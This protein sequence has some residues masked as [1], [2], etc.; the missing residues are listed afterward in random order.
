MMHHIERDPPVNV[1]QVASF[2]IGAGLT[3]LGALALLYLIGVVLEIVIAPGDSDLVTWVVENTGGEDL[4]VSGKVNE[5]TFEFRSSAALQYM[6][7]GM[8]ALFL[9]SLVMRIVQGI[10][11]TGMK[12]IE[13]SKKLEPREPAAPDSAVSRPGSET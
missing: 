3:G 11:T 4:V 12:L 8:F 1:T 13:F 6:I 2:W 5:A 9:V 10:T 7:Y